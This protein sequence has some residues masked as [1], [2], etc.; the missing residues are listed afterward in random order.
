MSDVGLCVRAC[1]SFFIMFCHWAAMPDIVRVQLRETR[2]ACFARAAV[3]DDTGGRICVDGFAAH[4]HK[5]CA[6][7]F[8][9]FFVRTCQRAPGAA[10]LRVS[11]L[12]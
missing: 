8:C 4:Q 6:F 1:A 9:F 7:F 11:E 12:V 10:V 3:I 2:A 5:T